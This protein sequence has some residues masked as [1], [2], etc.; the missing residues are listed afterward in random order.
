MRVSDVSKWIQCEKMALSSTNEGRYNRTGIAS[1]VGS[2]THQLLTGMDPDPVN[3]RQIAFDATTPTMNDA[4]RQAERMA[5]AAEDTL[6]RAGYYV[7]STEETVVLEDISGHLDLQTYHES[8]G[9]G[10]IDLKTGKMFGPG[11]WLQV[12]GYLSLGRNLSNFKYGGILRTVRSKKEDI[13]VSLEIRP[14]DG[15]VESWQARMDR[16]REVQEGSL[17]LVNPGMHCKDCVLE[18]A[19]RVE[20]GI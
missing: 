17:P 18:C 1:V 13:D 7:I 16:I 5:D 6:D 20:G 12:G 10:V 14:A 9:S 19:V 15:L 4:I 3:E 11:S 2:M 8:K